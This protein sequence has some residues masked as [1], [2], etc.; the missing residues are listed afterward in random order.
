MSEVITS[1]ALLGAAISP[2][3]VAYFAY[4]QAQ[5][6][7]KVAHIDEKVEVIHTAT[8]SMKDA[9]VLATAKA[10]LAQGKAEGRAE[11]KA[12]MRAD[13]ADGSANE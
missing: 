9:L 5:I 11:K 10:S 13:R 2:V 3:L 7:K 1:L 6:A 4:K 12:E 8:N